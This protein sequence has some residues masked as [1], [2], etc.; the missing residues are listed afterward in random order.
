MSVLV[1]SLSLSLSLSVCVCVCVC[2]CVYVLTSYRI[3]EPLRR[4]IL[5]IIRLYYMEMQVP[6]CGYSYKHAVV[7]LIHLMYDYRTKYM[8][9]CCKH[10]VS[11]YIYT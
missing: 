10:I 7:L 11:D 6:A 2:M 3:K 9:L 1:L 4:R 5:F 8:C